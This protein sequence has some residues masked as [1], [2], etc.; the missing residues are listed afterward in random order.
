MKKVLLVLLIVLLVLAILCAAGVFLFRHFVADQIMDK[1]GMENPDYVPEDVQPLDGDY[2]YAANE[3]LLDKI[4]GTWESADGRWTMALGEDCGIT[5]SLDGET[6]LEDTLQ[7][8]YLQPGDE[9]CT[10]LALSSGTNI[11]RRGD[12]SQTGEIASLWHEPA[13]SDIHGRLCMVLTDT[14]ANEETVE[15]TKTTAQ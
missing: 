3:L 9:R 11:L 6:A 12:G 2:T 10:E 15:F 7:F 13:D 4:T 8:T 1:G 5:L 14:D